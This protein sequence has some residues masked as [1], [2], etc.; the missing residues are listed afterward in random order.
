MYV[1]NRAR[2]R[3]LTLRLDALNPANVLQRGYSITRSLPSRRVVRTSRSVQIQ[4]Q[5]EIQLG[6]GYLLC[7]VEGNNPNGEKNI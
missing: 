5:V 7:R 3:E 1:L 2:H 6:S 4:Q